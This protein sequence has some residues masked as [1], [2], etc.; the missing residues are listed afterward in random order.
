ML[1]DFTSSVT[2]EGYYVVDLVFTHDDVMAKEDV[3]VP[4]MIYDALKRVN[5]ESTSFEKEMVN[6]F[7]EGMFIR[8]D[9]Y[10]FETGVIGEW[11]SNIV[12]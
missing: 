2:H 11:D 8:L 10:K 12:F 1:L 4:F 6:A 7:L 3:V 5:V 9:R